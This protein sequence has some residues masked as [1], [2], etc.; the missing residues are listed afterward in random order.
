[1]N[2]IFLQTKNNLKKYFKKQIV[3]HRSSQMNHQS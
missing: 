1:M 3:C 2:I